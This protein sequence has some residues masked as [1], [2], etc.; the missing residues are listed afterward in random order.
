MQAKRGEIGRPGMFG[1]TCEIE[2]QNELGLPDATWTN[3]DGS[4]L[5]SRLRPGVAFRNYQCVPSR[6]A[7]RGGHIARVR[8]DDTFWQEFD[9]TPRTSIASASQ[10]NVERWQALLSDG[11]H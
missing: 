4:F 8:E 9:Y 10:E 11:A 6:D 7:Y 5:C 3:Q 2:R 1:R